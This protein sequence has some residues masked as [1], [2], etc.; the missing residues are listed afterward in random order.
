MLKRFLAVAAFAAILVP[1][2]AFAVDHSKQWGV[3]YYDPEAPIGVRYQFS[4]KAAF[5]FGLGFVKFDGE[6]NS[7]SPS[8]EKSYMQYHVEV[9]VPITLVKMDRA[10]FFFR[11]G[12]LMRS[13]PYQ[14]DNGTS[15]SDERASETDIKLHLGAEWHATD[16]LSLSVGH[17]LT[18]A[19]QKPVSAGSFEGSKPEG[20]TVIFSEGLSLTSI[21]FRWYF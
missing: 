18:I 4:E 21:G 15:V 11:P 2:S 1:S 9:G 8:S 6:D 12:L 14:L 20:S 5:D 10:D 3:G 7:T 17:G 16:N 13:I 19:N